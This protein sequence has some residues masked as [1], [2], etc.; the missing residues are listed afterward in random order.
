MTSL[1][2]ADMR[3]FQEKH[4]G[5]EEQLR[6]RRLERRDSGVSGWDLYVPR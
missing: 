4:A 1:A 3:C 6:Q 5:Q 2:D